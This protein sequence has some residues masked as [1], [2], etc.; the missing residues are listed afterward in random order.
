MEIRLNKFINDSG[1]CSRREADKYIEDRRVTV[2]GKVATLGTKIKPTDRVMV[3]GLELQQQ[4]D[5][6]YL[7]LNKPIGISSTTDTTDKTNVIDFVN[8]PIRIFHIGRL[9]KD[10][11]GLL[12]LTNDGS[13][14]NKILRAGNNHEKEYEVT[15]DRPI[16]PQF[17]EKMSSGVPI[18]GTV[19]KRCK[20]VQVTPNKFNIALTQGLNRQIR[21]MCTAL[22]YEATN[23]RRV[24]IMNIQLGNLAVGQWRD[25]RAE[26]VEELLESVKNS[27]ER[28]IA[29]RG[30]GAS[31]H[32]LRSN[33]SH[34]KGRLNNREEEQGASKK[35]SRRN[36]HK[37]TKNAAS[38]KRTS[39]PA[40]TFKNTN[41]PK[42]KTSNNPQRKSTQKPLR[43]R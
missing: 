14:V 7:A 41:K 19:T 8:F 42:A 29:S 5:Y 20:V 4:T 26:E 24:R 31:K 32:A 6:I 40:P 34:S 1:Y 15:V 35:P 38:K 12:L 23:L 3:N 11:E 2:N 33:F 18:L 28:E 10:S 43:K 37:S 17:I 27:E 22:G 13:I 36:V 25:L 16:T 21:R 39:A 9:D 30:A